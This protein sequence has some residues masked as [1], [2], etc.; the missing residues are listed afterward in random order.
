MNWNDWEFIWRRQEP[1]VG[2]SANL[3]KLKTSFEA[4]HQTLARSM[5]VRDF[6]ELAAAVFLSGLF[7]W[8]GWR[9]G[10]AGWPFAIVVAL[11]LGVAVV[12][13]RERLRA[14][15]SRVSPSAPLLEKVA[16]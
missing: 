13:I 1:P 6:S 3:Q 5:L 4:R 15:R 12:F 10:G 14:R 16:A 7:A 2:S 9:L 11:F 8:R